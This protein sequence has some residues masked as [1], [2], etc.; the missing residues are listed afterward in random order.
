MRWTA[1]RVARRCSFSSPPTAPKPSNPPSP[2]GPAA[3][4]RPLSSHCPTRTAG[5]GC[6]RS[7]GGGLHLDLQNEEA[8]IARTEGASPAFIQ[9]LIR[10]AAMVAAEEGATSNGSLRVTDAYFDTALRE[11]I[12]GGGDLT[13]TLLGFA[14]EGSQPSN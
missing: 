4:T 13:R 3:S 14:A 8:L 9:E 10:K 11:M 1:W 2:P 12:Y 6:W 5:R 7:T